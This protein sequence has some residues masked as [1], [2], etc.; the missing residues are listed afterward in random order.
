MNS[1]TDYILSLI[2]ILIGLT[3][4]LNIKFRLFSTVSKTLL[5]SPSQ[6]HLSRHPHLHAFQPGCSSAPSTHHGFTPSCD[7]VHTL[8][9]AWNTFPVI[10]IW[11]TPT[12]HLRSLFILSFTTSYLNASYVSG[13]TLRA[14]Y[15]KPNNAQCP[16][17]HETYIL[18]Q[19]Q[20][21]YSK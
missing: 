5:D 10:L 15:T 8:L 14:G 2:K 4:L 3:S 6:L 12:Y 18:A 13:S 17:P 7:S 16:Y 21:I 1:N 9:S 11:K 20:I 19:N